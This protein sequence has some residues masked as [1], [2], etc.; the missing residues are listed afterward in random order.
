MPKDEVLKRFDFGIEIKK[1]WVNKETG[2][3]FVKG[4]ASD[5]GV[6]HHKERFSEK[7]LEGMVSCIKNSTPADVIL[8]P[9]H[10][11]TFEIGKAVNATIVPSE[12]SDELKALEV[13]IELDMEYPQAKSL[14]KE[15]ESGKARKQMSVGGFLNPDNEKPYF[16]EEKSYE[17]EDGNIFYDYI[18][19]LDDLVLDHIAVTRKDQ[20][21]NARTGF[22][23]AIA[24]SLDLEKPKPKVVKQKKEDEEM[25]EH[26]KKANKLGEVISK[27]VSSFFS[28]DAEEK[29]KIAKQKA[30]EAL[31]A[32]KDV[33]GEEG[34]KNHLQAVV[35]DK[36]KSE[37]PKE[38]PA[39][40][41]P[42]AADPGQPADPENPQEPE[43]G[44][45]ENKS[46][47]VVETPAVDVDT[48]KSNIVAEVSKSL[49]KDQEE[50][51]Q[52]VAK[53]LGDVIAQTLKSQLDPLKQEIETLKSAT[54]S[55]KGLQGQE[56]TTPSDKE[57]STEEED[58]IWKG[59]LVNALPDHLK[60]EIAS[61][62]E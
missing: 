1:A 5:T 46:L 58:S 4:I 19:V 28:N 18:L 31:D 3:H 55:S 53:S 56:N 12:V 52:E 38:E 22:S 39:V 30:Q 35:D 51:F 49:S 17:Q 13:E 61:K 11:D 60:S 62:N 16:W 37:D 43:P 34:L 10:W 33:D 20:A 36:V 48:L 40:D 32:L 21:A 7:A 25:P 24:K 44:K 54:G 47:Y 26:E 15:V 41:E 6:D 57:K 27:A 9:T 45:E 42:P 59:I 8:L 2:Q 14:Y 50:T 29:K 23:E